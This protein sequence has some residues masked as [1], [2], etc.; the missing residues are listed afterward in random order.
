M[1]TESQSPLAAVVYGGHTE[2]YSGDLSRVLPSF[3]S[4]DCLLV[5][6]GA[7]WRLPFRA[8]PSMLCTLGALCG[9]LSRHDAL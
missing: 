8:L 4:L 2:V 3:L 5:A 6:G 9:Q 1:H 7:C